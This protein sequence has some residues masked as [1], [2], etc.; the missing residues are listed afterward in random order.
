MLS[1]LNALLA[2]L[3]VLAEPIGWLTLAVFVTAI[4]L[5]YVDREYA[6]YAYVGA[7]VLFS[8]FWFTLIQPFL[9][10]DESIIR[11]V[12]A[13]VAVPL[14]LLIAKTF[15]QG[16]DSLFTLSRAIVFMGL[17]YVPFLLIEPLREQAILLVTNHTAFVMDALGYDP[18]VVTTLDDVG[19][20]RE[21]SGKTEMYENCFVFADGSITYTIIL[22]CTGIGSMSVIVGLIAA[23]DAPLRRKLQAT[24][25]V[26]PVI[27][28][29]NIVRNVFIGISYGHQYMHFFPD[30]TMTVFSLDT[31]LRVSY[32]WADRILAQSAS[33]V[34]LV[35][36]VWAVVKILPEVLGPIEDV[37]YLLTGEEHD[38][39]A[40]LDLEREPTPDPA[41]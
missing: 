31:S 7:W 39:A 11:G 14:A 27:Y 30:I 18:T 21:I 25:L 17:I 2:D 38:L 6:R 41:D 36:I 22:A 20:E 5:E 32:I 12:G 26:V 16:R 4:A 8:G 1:R 33:V 3:S 37:L 34:A 35:L 29:L 24:A 40:A 23:V 9:V 19:V 15:Y 10:V 28:V 13:A